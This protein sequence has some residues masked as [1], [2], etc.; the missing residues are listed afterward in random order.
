MP[1]KSPLKAKPLR[2]P[3]ES[4]DRQ[5]QE[6]MYDKVLPYVVLAFIF[7]VVAG[8][9]WWRWYF[10]L[11]PSPWLFTTIAA[12]ALAM[13]IWKAR[14][15]LRM[16]KRIKLG[17]DGEK[18]VG[19]FLERLRESGAQVF[20]D[21]PGDCFNLD[22]VV[23]HESGF[24]VIETKTHSIS[25]RGEPKLFYDGE[26]VSKNGM[27]P[28]RNPITQVRAARK[29]LSDLIKESTG[30][31]FPGKAVV[32]YPGWYIEATAEA[33]ASDVWVLNPKA[34]PAFIS[35]SSAQ[36]SPEDVKLCS[37]HLSRYIRGVG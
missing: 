37:Y 15:G 32:V 3:G 36:I 29:W 26:H 16:T 13:S 8:L 10:N 20:H 22:H 7:A 31:T 27:W 4:S 30:R 35:Q 34:L 18:A 17:R 5:L 1:G 23:I 2:N 19:Q 28:D 12:L 24:Y 6:I 11:P 33:K 21:I 25:V 9:E 14:W